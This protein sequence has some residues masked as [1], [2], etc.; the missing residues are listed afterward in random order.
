VKYL[1]GKRLK[2]A[3]NAGWLWLDRHRERLNA[4]NVFP[5][6]DGDTGTNM[7]LTLKAAVA[8]ANMAKSDSLQDVADSIALHSL[9]GAQ[10]NSGVIMSQYFKG[11]AEYI[12]RRK[13]LDLNGVAGVFSA[14]ADSAYG[15]MK[16]PMEGT[17]LT[18]IREMAE[19]LQETK[20]R[21]SSMK[22]LL[23]SAVERG[24]QSLSET[25]SKLKVLA[26]ADVVDAGGQGF[27]HFIEGICYLIRTGELPSSVNQ[28]VSAD[29]AP[30]IIVEH[31]KF[32]YCSEFLVKGNGFDTDSIKSKLENLGD[33]LIVARAAIQQDEYLRIHI[34][35]DVP[36]TI[37]QIAASFGEIE[38]GKVDDMKAQNTTMRKWRA[39]FTG[40]Q[41]RQTVR[42]LTDST[43]DLPADVAEFYDIEVVPLKVTFGSDVYHDGID[44]EKDRFY[45]MLADSA[46]LPT[47]SQPSPGE[48]IEYYERVFDR[49]DCSSLI[50]IHVSSKLSGTFNS[51]VIAGKDFKGKII[52]L[53]S[54]SVSLGLGML[55]IVAAELARDGFAAQDIIKTIERHKNNQKLFFTLGSLEYLIKGG[56]VSG[57]RGFL[58]RFLGLRPLLSL[59]DGEIVPIDKARSDE[60]LLEKIIK[61]LAG[62]YPGGRWAVGHTAFPTRSDEIVAVLKKR[63][64]VENVLEGEIGPAVGTHAGPGS[65][66]IFY[67]K[68]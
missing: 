8:G 44:L 6:A 3:I 28:L 24:K 25:K 62:E 54:R 65:W 7:A 67:T 43:C 19:H 47:T 68:G 61:S 66:G 56:R 49:G 13:R 36:D 10:G 23:Q 41:T 18:V 11:V 34:H 58:G 27:I 9:R 32:R 53:D 4:I 15:A 63:L 2:R 59:V 26:D 16:D 38:T 42:I 35:T 17:I 55:A 29:E 50:S 21:F 37:R 14:G 1:D 12:R 31:T 46:Q 33:S 30:R 39:K 20:S 52:H 57:A 48:F 51:A 40:K 22:G 64:G 45:R 5:V 60:K